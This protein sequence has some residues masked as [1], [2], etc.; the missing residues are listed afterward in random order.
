MYLRSRLKE[1]N[2]TLYEIDVQ[3]EAN[4]ASDISYNEIG[5]TKKDVIT[6]EGGVHYTHGFFIIETTFLASM[7][8]VDL[9]TKRG[10]YV[11]MS[12]LLTGSVATFKQKFNK[13]K[14]IEPGLLQLVFRSDTDV[15]MEL[16]GDNKPMRYIRIF[17]SR[18][19]YLSLLKSESWINE[20]TF[21]HEVVK[22]RYVHFGK[23]LIPVSPVLLDTLSDILNNNY[24]GS[25]KKYYLEHK[26][27]DLFLQLYINRQAGKNIP[28]ITDD[29]RAKLESARAY[30][31]TH[32][33]NPPTI[34]QLSRIISLNEL[35]L[36]TGFKEKFGST[37][38]DYITKVR[39]NKAKKML[40]DQQ[41]VSEV[42]SQLGYKSVSHFITSF[43]K[44]YGV[45]PRQSILSKI[46]DTDALQVLSFF[47]TCFTDAVE[48]FQDGC[49]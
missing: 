26:L 19:F 31:A 23:N 8:C 41:S 18:A 25:I 27:K 40:L 30:L 38:H 20:C 9:L 29:M 4:I 42:S 37:I 13:V 16:P 24:A 46:F 33:F 48:L 28:A 11:Q 2:I 35:K 3:D 7:P 22:G 17:L 1:E 43:K 14:D 15:A 6:V 45:T 47:C 39:M 44:S 36:K 32:Y 10:D 21:H 49:L 5:Y 34:K 12:L